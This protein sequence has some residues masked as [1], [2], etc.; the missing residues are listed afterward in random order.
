MKAQSLSGGLVAHAAALS[1]R[2]T[3]QSRYEPPR[4]VRPS[5][6]IPYNHP[7][8]EPE[9]ACHPK[10]Q[11]LSP[12]SLSKVITVYMM[13]PTISCHCQTLLA[14]N[15][16]NKKAAPEEAAPC[17]AVKVASAIRNTH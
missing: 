17:G 15:K 12:Q 3:R 11:S 1:S 13:C 6:A 7:S 9:P 2:F 10:L 16:K 14:K 4:A 5:V 8:T